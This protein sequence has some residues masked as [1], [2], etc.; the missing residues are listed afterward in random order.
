MNKKI[1]VAYFSASG[2][3]KKVAEEIEK[4][5]KADLFEIKPEN[6]YTRQ[7]LDWQD[8]KS[9][10][11]IEMNDENSRPKILNKLS[12]INE[13]ETIFLGFPI[14]W[15]VAPKIINTF[16]ESYNLQGIDI[17]PFCTSGGSEIKSCEDALKREYPELNWRKGKRL[18]GN[19]TIAEF[20]H[21]IKE[22]GV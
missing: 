13:Y 4:I 20:E 1:L 14:W 2:V 6:S 17:I 22:E 3:T 5:F 11:S 9:R 18:T 12:N 19:E 15:Y 16:V 8:K 21:W 7:D 10:S